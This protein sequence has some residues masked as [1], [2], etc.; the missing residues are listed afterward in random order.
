MSNP[1]PL[2]SVVFGDVGARWC[3]V[4]APLVQGWCISIVGG[5]ACIWEKC[6][7]LTNLI[8]PLNVPILV[9]LFSSYMVGVVGVGEE[10]ARCR[11]VIEIRRGLVHR[12]CRLVQS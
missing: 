2:V 5:I 9:D 8:R 7:N 12:W 3:T 1:D 11:P 10:G 6:T 4:G